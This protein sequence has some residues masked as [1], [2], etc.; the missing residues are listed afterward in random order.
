VTQVVRAPPSKRQALNQALVLPKERKENKRK[1]T[2]AKRAGGM[3]QVVQHL[4]NKHPRHCDPNPSATK[5][6][7][8]KNKRIKI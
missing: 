7:K 8:K 3:T 6:K 1:R 2:K 5:K 4:P